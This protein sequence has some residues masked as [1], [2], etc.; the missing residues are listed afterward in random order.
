MVLV[1]LVVL[2]FDEWERIGHV[3]GRDSLIIVEGAGTAV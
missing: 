2:S 1:G 3:A